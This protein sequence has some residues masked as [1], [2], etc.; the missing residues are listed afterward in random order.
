MSGTRVKILIGDPWELGEA[1]G[2]VKPIGILA[3]ESDI[4][5]KIH[6]NEHIVYQGIGHI[7]FEVRTRYSNGS[8]SD[9]PADGLACSFTSK[10]G[11]PSLNFTGA[12]YL[13]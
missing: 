8:F 2:W 10:D 1:V 5:G 13:Y 12:I 7:S 4:L 11:H 6:L 9:I 3:F